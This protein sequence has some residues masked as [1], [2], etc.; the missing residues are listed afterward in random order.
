MIYKK[1]QNLLKVLPKTVLFR[2]IA[3]IFSLEKQCY[4]ENRVFRELCKRRRA[5]T[6]LFQKREHYSR[7]G[8]TLFEEIRYPSF[9]F[10]LVE[11][12][13]DL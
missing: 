11:F 8:G 1:S 4:L 12:G 13:A 7:L 9:C 10:R 5:C 2:N 6:K 3:L